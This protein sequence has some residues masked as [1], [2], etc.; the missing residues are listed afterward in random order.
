MKK[1]LHFVILAVG[2][3]AITVLIWLG[4]QRAAIANPSG[5]IADPS[6]HP[7]KLHPNKLHPNK[8][9][10][11]EMSQTAPAALCDLE[12]GQKIDL[13]NANL[14]DFMQCPGFYPTLAKSLVEHSPYT[15]VDDVLKVA[16]LSDRQKQMLKDNLG[17][18]TLSEPVVPIE[19]RMPPRPAMR[20]NP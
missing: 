18:F 15:Q 1:F 7:N 14:I 4:L 6:T 13:N 3:C 20:A 5:G 19:M 8:L 17:S 9:L 10:V 11:A 16:D 2:V 12:A